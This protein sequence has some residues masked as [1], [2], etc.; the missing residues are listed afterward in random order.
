MTH[1]ACAARSQLFEVSHSDGSEFAAQRAARRAF[2]CPEDT[3]AQSVAQKLPPQCEQTAHLPGESSAEQAL[4][5]AAS[6]RVSSLGSGGS[7]QVIHLSVCAS[8]RAA[9]IP[10]PRGTSLFDATPPAVNAALC[11][12]VPRSLLSAGRV[13]RRVA[14]D[15]A[16]G[17]ALASSLAS[18]G[19]S[20]RVPS[21]VLVDS[22]ECGLGNERVASAWHALLDC[23]ASGSEALVLAH[24]GTNGGEVTEE[25]ERTLRSLMAEHGFLFTNKLLHV[26]V[27]TLLAAQKRE[28]SLA[29]RDVYFETAE[30]AMSEADEEGF[31][32]DN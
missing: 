23:T 3:L 26:G 21:L 17:E 9:Q 30:R 2:L 13:L 4:D 32:E 1:R 7:L 22:L 31:E 16:N 6:A 18:K 8:P 10:W 20:G 19:V 12:S 11:E 28:P 25:H 15:F 24:V 5:D 14:T 29:Q 27:F